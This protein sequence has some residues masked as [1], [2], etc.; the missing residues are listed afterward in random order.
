MLEEKSGAGGSGREW[1][2]PCSARLRHCVARAPAGRGSEPRGGEKPS[3][4]NLMTTIRR[5][6]VSDQ[7]RLPISLGPVVSDPRPA[8]R[9][10][11]IATAT[12]R[13]LDGARSLGVGGN[14]KK[15]CRWDSKRKCRPRLRRCLWLTEVPGGETHEKLR[16]PCSA[17]SA[18]VGRRAPIVNV[19]NADSES[20]P[21]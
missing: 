11:G 6:R 10:C 4:A 16:D 3:S 7:R 1:R 5:A 8:R 18:E 21:S 14:A 20:S 9:P 17:R 15:T 13:A 12:P 19:F 2:N